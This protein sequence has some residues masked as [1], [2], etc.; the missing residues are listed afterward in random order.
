MQ[1]R[2]RA[3]IVPPKVRRQAV[4]LRPLLALRRARLQHR[5]VDR[6]V[7]ALRI[8]LRKHRSNSG[9]PYAAAIVSSSGAI[10]G[11]CSRI[12]F[13]SVRALHR[14]I[15]PFHAKFPAARNCSAVCWSGFSRK[16][17]T[18]RTG[19][20]SSAHSSGIDARPARCTRSRS[21]AA[22][23]ARPAPRC[24][25]PPPP[26]CTPARDHLGKALH[27]RHH[28]VRRKDARAPSPARS[29]PAETPPA[30]TPEPCC[31]P[32]ARSEYAPAA[33]VGSCSAIVLS[34]QLVRDHPDVARR[35]PPAAAASSVCW[36]IV[37]SPSSASTCLARA[38][39]LRGQNRVPLPPPESPA[40]TD[41][42]RLLLIRFHR[43]RKADAAREALRIR[44]T[45]VRCTHLLARLS[46]L[47]KNSRIRSTPL[48][49]T[50]A[51][52]AYDSRMCSVVPNASPGTTTTCASLSSRAATSAADRD[53]AL[54]EERAHIRIH[55]ERALRHRAGQPRNRLEALQ[56][57]VAQLDVVRPH[58]RHALL[59]RRSARR[60]TPA[61]PCSPR[62]TCSATAACSSRAMIGFGPSAKPARQPVIA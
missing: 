5:V 51:D 17:L 50:S 1:R 6:D 53:A 29:S 43:I 56:H 27:V 52:T 34:S 42:L 21:P 9:V 7:L 2:P 48:S 24:S 36:I 14:K 11:A 38:R 32:P 4:D 28:V 58:L 30:R 45:R 20:A 59:R 13:A 15:P 23:A 26:A 61:A 10:S 31:A 39:R 33:T 54:A 57:A 47:A 62:S 19:I 60:S 55:I 8:L 35:R 3:Q 22:S 37:R 18:R 16:R 46:Q 49:I 41:M 12:A 25:R 40:Q 44:S